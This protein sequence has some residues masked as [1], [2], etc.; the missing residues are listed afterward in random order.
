MPA[1]LKAAVGAA[2]TAGALTAALTVVLGHRV[3]IGSV[4]ELMGFMVALGFTWAFP[5]K[6]LRR[7]ETEAFQLDEAF[8]V[9]MTLLLPPLG[10]VAAF[11][12]AAFVSRLVNSRTSS[13][14]SGCPER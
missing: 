10:V 13:T 11:G 12:I 14:L 1:K 4:P 9:A 6:L 8:L 7:E 2:V 3:G 5:I